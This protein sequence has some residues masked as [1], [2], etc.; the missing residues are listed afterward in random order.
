[1][2]RD[3]C[4]Q[5]TVMVLGG[6]GGWGVEGVGILER[7]LYT[8]YWLFDLTL[9][10]S[11]RP[12][13]GMVGS[14]FFILSVAMKTNNLQVCRVLVINALSAVVFEC[15]TSSINLFEHTTGILAICWLK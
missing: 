3:R 8:E 1:M 6:D 9:K 7:F 2:E 5:S 11:E 4:V 10:G 12:A 13:S 14:C 15:I